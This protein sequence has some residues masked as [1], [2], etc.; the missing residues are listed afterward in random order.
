MNQRAEYRL[1]YPLLVQP[2]V[3]LRCG[4]R[5]FTSRVENLSESGALCSLPRNHGLLAGDPLRGRIELAQ[6]RAFEFAGRCLRV[7]GR[8]VAIVFDAGHRA[9]LALI[10]EEQRVV[11]RRFPEW[12]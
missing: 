2:R 10:F 9:P 6:R 7:E 11:R 3:T 1:R 4:E 5:E 8:E 12:S